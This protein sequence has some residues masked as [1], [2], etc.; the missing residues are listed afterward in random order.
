VTDTV[1]T[2][3]LQALDALPEG[4]V[5][6]CCAGRRYIATRSLFNGGRSVKLVAEELG[7]RDFVSL[8]LYRLKHGV[9]LKPCEMSRT[10]V[11]AFV[12]GFRPD[13]DAHGQET[14]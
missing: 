2:S 14:A 8:N 13:R 9:L 11:I 5:T 6:G 3:F 10:R 7:G 1:P 12:T 4:S